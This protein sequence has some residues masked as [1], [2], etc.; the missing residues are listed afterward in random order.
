MI[1]AGLVAL[2]QANAGLEALIGTRIYPDVLPDE[3]TLPAITYQFLGGN[4]KP[5]FNTSGMQK[6]RVEFNCWSASWPQGGTKAQA[7][8]VRDALVAALNGYQGTLTDGT[9][10][11]TADLIHPGM[12]FFEREL[13]QYRCLIEFYLLYT[14]TS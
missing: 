5:T 9:R 3:P 2:L 13:L 1:D 7:A 12:S 4:S 11:L 14:F 10:L 6:L 8:A